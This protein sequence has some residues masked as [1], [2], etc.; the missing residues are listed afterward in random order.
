M[1]LLMRPDTKPWDNKLVRQAAVY[2]IDRDGIINSLL[3]GQAKRL[4]GPVNPGAYAYDPNLQPRYAFSLEKAKALLAQ[5]GYPN[6]VDVELSVPVG[7]YTQDKQIGEAVAQMLNA[8]G[9]RTK[10]DTQEWSTFADNYMKGKLG[11]YYVGRAGVVDPGRPLSQFF[12]TGVSPRVGY[13]NPQVDAL[14]AKE[15]GAFDPAERKKIL[16]EMMSLVTEEAPADFMWTHKAIWGAAKNV[17]FTPRLD[18]RMYARDMRV[19]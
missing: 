10:L 1:M 13:S 8:A 16:G 17:E 15:R 4:D 11:F 14:F 6:G 19:K 18:D 3:Q 2:A 9:F 7:R 12:E 5:A